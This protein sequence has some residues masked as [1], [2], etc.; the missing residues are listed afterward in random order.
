M[1]NFK[2]ALVA[3]LVLVG[4]NNMN[5][6][7]KNNPWAI[8]FGVNFVD[9][10]P[11]GYEGNLTTNGNQAGLF[12]EFFNASEHYNY[13]PTISSISVGKYLDSGFSL[14][15]G[16]N[17]NKISI[18]GNNPEYNP[19]DLAMLGIDANLKY[20]ILH[21]FKSDG[22]LAPYLKLGGGY[23]FLDW[24]GTGML[25][26]GLGFDVWMS[27]NV[28]LNIQ[29]MYKH[30]FD[31]N[32]APFFQHNLGLAVKFGGVDTDGDGI[33]DADD[34]CPETFGLEAFGGCPDTDGDGIKDSADNCP[35]VAGPVEFNGCPDTDGD[36][37]VDV[38]D[39]CPKVKGTKAN[40][41]CPDTD[42]DGV[43][44]SKDS[45]PKVKG[46][47]A[48]KGCPWPDTDKDGIL[49]KDD[50]CPKVPGLA[51]LKGCPA[52]KE[53]EVITKEAKAKLDAYAK[54]IYFNSAKS[55]FKTGVISKLDAIAAIMQEYSNA[56]FLIEGHT[57]S[58]GAS[59]PNQV[60]SEKRA[61]TVMN[62][63]VGKG[64]ASSRLSAVG[65]GEEYPVADNKTKAGRAENR[66]VE[67]NLRK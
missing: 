27:D 66:R 28:A 65:F 24:E 52:P 21:A 30:S 54:T 53:V 5:A 50:K 43:I 67:I 18:K 58:Q 33:Y 22:W 60:L 20:N 38:K 64:V 49:D 4:L 45:C 26:G 1:R 16:A 41:G 57:D 40:N 62:Y 44:D 25:N 47:K 14:E 37:I 63:L 15:L 48:N 29:T 35:N 39:S 42:G 7:D 9:Y 10:Q 12:D 46:A 19:G 17:I 34:A 31:N 11:T 3:M 59:A 61:N 13:I 32:F 51:E 8:N 36:G 55:S 56:N 6:Q 2:I 23:N